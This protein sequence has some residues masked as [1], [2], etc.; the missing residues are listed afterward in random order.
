[1]ESDVLRKSIAAFEDLARFPCR[2]RVVDDKFDALVL[3]QIADD[4]SID[5]RDWFKFPGPISFVM[6]PG[7]P[8]G[9]VWFPFGGHAVAQ[10]RGK[11]L[12]QVW[13]AL[14]FSFCR[15]RHSISG[16]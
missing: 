5:P 1:M 10:F 12:D 7:E 3:R 14:T 9:R 8:C 2:R 11:T 4:L 16:S 15:S 6:R 13:A